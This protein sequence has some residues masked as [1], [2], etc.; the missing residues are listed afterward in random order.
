MWRTIL[1][2]G[3]LGCAAGA[4]CGVDSDGDGLEDCVEVNT[5]FTDPAL[6][7]SDGDGEADGAEVDCAS[8]PLD[9]AQACYACGWRRNDPGTLA[10]NG[11]D[12]GDT[13]ANLDLVD[14]CRDQVKLWDFSGKYY[15][16]FLTAAW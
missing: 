1:P 13:I 16:M 14:Q 11:D 3:M 4:P 12:I 2:L 8:D 15:V 9:A 6:P 7:D 5:T 10:S